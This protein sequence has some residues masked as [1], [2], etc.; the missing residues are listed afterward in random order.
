MNGWDEMMTGLERYS[1]Q[2]SNPLMFTRLQRWMQRLG[3]IKANPE[4]ASLD[5]LGM[6]L[7]RIHV[8]PTIDLSSLYPQRNRKVA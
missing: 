8:R 5:D 3:H 7:N 4:C 2:V 1:R 6:R